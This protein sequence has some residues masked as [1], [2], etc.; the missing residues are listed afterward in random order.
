M[1]GHADPPRTLI[2]SWHWPPTNKASAGVLGALFQAAPP[3]VFRV[4]TRRPVVAGDADDRAVPS[5]FEARIP[6]EFVANADFGG[7]TGPFTA[8]A[9]AWTARRMVS[10]AVALH[11]Q[12][13]YSRVLAVYPHRWSLWAGSRIARRLQLPFI[14]Y[15]HDLF[16]EGAPYRGALWQAIWRRV[17]RRLLQQA[18]MILVPTDAFAKHYRRRGLERCRVLPHCTTNV[19]PRSSNASAGA[20]HLVYSGL[21]YEA[22][23]AAV[24]PFV[25]A[26][27]GLPDLR[28]TYNCNPDGCGGLMGRV[29]GRWRPHREAMRALQS[30][31]AGVVLL[32]DDDR[33][34]EEVM[35]C[36]P[37]KIIDY[38]SIGL[39][40]LAVVPAGSFVDR[41][42]TD[43]GCGVVVRRADA[44]S[45]RSAIGRLRDADHRRR[46]SRAA[47]ELAERLRND[48]WMPQL[49]G[50]LG[51]GAGRR[52]GGF[53]VSA[54]VESPAIDDSW[55]DGAGATEGGGADEVLEGGA[56]GL[57]VGIEGGAG[58]PKIEVSTRHGFLAKSG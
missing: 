36:F 2:V 7:P 13:A 17:D 26:T 3:G 33:L 47:T 38:V 50:W 30:A 20:L 41:L 27:Q 21:I 24:R 9:S 22:H 39:P 23:A 1:K 54:T 10:R 48:A 44:A 12:W 16:A 11:R 18:W 49:L 43:S 46:M 8:A 14:P 51:V 6:P 4:V 58:R 25:A 19:V 45:I 29:G 52:A 32:A 57:P 40:I 5:D 34:R 31:D 28:V 56:A 37:S 15:M 42:V 53:T 55:G 35:G